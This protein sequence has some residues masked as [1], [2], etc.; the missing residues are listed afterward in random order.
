[1][2]EVIGIE[3][4]DRQ[5]PRTRRIV[6]GVTVHTIDHNVN[7]T[8]GVAVKRFYFPDP[9]DK[10]NKANALKLGDMIEEIYYNSEKFPISYD[11]IETNV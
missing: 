4:I 2:F 9:V 10:R 6:K 11:L 3:R 1:M 5:D 7:I 8:E